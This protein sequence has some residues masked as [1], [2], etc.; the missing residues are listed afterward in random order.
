MEA[1][2]TQHKNAA[3]Q[4]SRSQSAEADA[5]KYNEIVYHGANFSWE[6]VDGA[7]DNMPPALL[8]HSRLR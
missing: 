6:E 1:A 3:E 5:E 2:V 8:L 4:A 7:G